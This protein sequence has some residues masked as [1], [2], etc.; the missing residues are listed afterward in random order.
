LW[1]AEVRESDRAL[2]WLEGYAAPT[3]TREE[4][5]TALAALPDYA[6][7]PTL[8][9]S[10]WTIPALAKVH[11]L[12]GRTNEALPE[13]RLFASSCHALVEPL[14]YVQAELAYGEALE[15]SG[16]TAS[17][18]AAYGVVL[19]RWGAAKRS[20]TAAAAAARAKTLGCAG[21]PGPK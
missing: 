17:A 8:T 7:I 12:A 18:C 15:A 10:G 4:A 3:Q 5:E 20:V 11:A 16:A 6:P 2:V 21:H 14:A 1:S 19:K 9:L 13:L